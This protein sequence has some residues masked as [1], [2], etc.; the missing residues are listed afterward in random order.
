MTVRN[1]AAH[2][3]SVPWTRD[4]DRRFVPAR[5]EAPADGGA[6]RS[7]QLVFAF[8]EAPPTPYP[9]SV[10][11]IAPPPE[12]SALP[13]GPPPASEE[14]LLAA[15]TLAVRSAAEIP[16]ELALTDNRR[17]MI[18]TRRRGAG[19]HVRLHRM[20]L[21]A[22]P[23]VQAALGR[24]LARRDARASRLVGEFIE[25]NRDRI[26]AAPP[27]LLRTSG[28]HHDLSSLLAEVSHAEF[29]GPLDGVRITWG[30]PG[31]ARRK[32]SIR[33]GTYSHEERLVRIHPS[34]DA[35]WVPRFFVRYIVFHELLHHVEPGI[36]RNGRTE[37]HTPAF[38][39]REQRYGDYARALAWEREHLPRLLRA[40]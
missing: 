31:A 10:Q 2:P 25:A 35:A 13:S 27:H 21:D 32:R 3:P 28:H 30:R 15:L 7:G 19:L 20:F 26:R 17:T 38:R 16:L 14:A 34:L 33:L 24:Y 11:I 5:R 4:P 12:A 18:S 23:L 40:G 39:A 9:S 6:P 36:E 8:E 1:P 29:G 37:F 22:G